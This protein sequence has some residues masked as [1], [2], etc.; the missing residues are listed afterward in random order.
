[1][2][3]LSRRA[4]IAG[5]LCSLIGRP[6]QAL[7]TPIPP[8]ELRNEL[9]KARLVGQGTLR[10]FGLLVYDARLWAA[11]KFQSD[12]YEQQAFALE[13]IYARKL[14]GE[15]IAERSIAEMRRVA[16]F[17]DAQEKR[18]LTAMKTAFPDVGANDRLLGLN[19]GQGGVRF[20]HNGR[21][22]AQIDDPEYARLFFGI[23][24]APQTS[25]PALR[26][27]LLGQGD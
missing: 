13:L 4:V 18:W 15:A 27:S 5:A 21:Q 3:P 23:W 25:A 2:S 19:D 12:R 11:P 9:P 7:A 14:E 16:P 17:G 1:M 20:F 26:S 6:M 22:T 10:F 8:T 24:L